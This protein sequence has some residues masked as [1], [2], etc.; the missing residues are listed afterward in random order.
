MKT[1]TQQI[2]IC[3]TQLNNT[4]REIYTIKCYVG[5]EISQINNR[6]LT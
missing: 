3:E 6:I 2:K 5:N 4:G 1:K